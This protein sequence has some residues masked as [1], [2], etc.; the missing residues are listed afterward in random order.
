MARR[1]RIAFA[2]DSLIEGRPGAAFFPLLAARLADVELL[3]LGRAGDT[4]DGLRQRLHG[5]GMPKVDATVVWI[6]TNDIVRGDHDA[7]AS[8]GDAACAWE[9]ALP[10][11]RR[12]YGDL[13][14]WVGT[15]AD[16]VTC[17]PPVFPDGSA[18][19]WAE[20]AA[21]FEALVR[22]CAAAAGASVADLAPAFATAR[23]GDAA[24]TVD[25]VHLNDAGAAVVATAFARLLLR[26]PRSEGVPSTRRRA[27]SSMAHPGTMAPCSGLPC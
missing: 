10:G 13:L 12:E 22:R 9:G 16:A 4:V 21:D 27:A 17:V 26:R 11:L 20:R 15:H 6:G 1:R 19:V 24:F 23:R 2:G 18:G 3:N 8:A 14:S 7:W 25:G 5:S